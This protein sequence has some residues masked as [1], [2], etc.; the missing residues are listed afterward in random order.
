MKILCGILLFIVL[1][2]ILYKLCVRYPRVFEVVKS[3]LD[4]IE[5]LI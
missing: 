5:D 4:A 1:L 2:F 3:I